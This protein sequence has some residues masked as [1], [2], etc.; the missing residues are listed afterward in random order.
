MKRTFIFL[1]VAVLLVLSGGG[2]WIYQQ[3]I[4]PRISKIKNITSILNTPIDAQNI[5][6]SEL[7]PGKNDFNG[8]VLELFDIGLMKKE[9]HETF[10]VEDLED[11]SSGCSTVTD[12]YFS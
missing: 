2:Y 9:K 1:C 3:K 10:Y 4:D 11:C 8:T 7:H 12:Y 5:A 6:F